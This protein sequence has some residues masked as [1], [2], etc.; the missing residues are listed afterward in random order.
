MCMS[1]ITVSNY[2]KL[3]LTDKSAGTVGLQALTS[4]AGGRQDGSERGT[5]AAVIPDRSHGPR[6]R[7]QGTIL[8][9]RDTDAI[10]DQKNQSK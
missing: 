8:L 2:M 4:V 5:E 10:S 9:E 1:R 6:T 7:P 3:K